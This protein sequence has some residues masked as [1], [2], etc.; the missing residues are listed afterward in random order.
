MKV[1]VGTRRSPLARTQTDHVCELLHRANPGIDCQVVAVETTGDLVRDRPLREIG[2]KGLFVKELD[3]A[4]AAGANDPETG[5][6]R[7]FVASFGEQLQAEADREQ[8]RT[9]FRGVQRH[10]VQPG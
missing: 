10:L 9:A 8:R 1:R 4:L 5:H 7:G 6:A 2:G 3:E